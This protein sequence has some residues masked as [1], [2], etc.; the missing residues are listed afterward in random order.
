M[1]VADRIR[2]VADPLIE[3][4]YDD[5]QVRTAVLERLGIGIG[6]GWRRD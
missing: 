6:G 5:M 4:G 1:D 2:A 3:R